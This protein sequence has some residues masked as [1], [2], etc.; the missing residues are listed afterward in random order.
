MKIVLDLSDL[1]ESGRVTSAEAER[2]R[3]LAAFTAQSLAVNLLVGFGLVA[4]VAGFAA[5]VP[6][7][8]TAVTL[9]AIALAGGLAIIFSRA[10]SWNLLGHICAVIGA[11][12]ICGGIS[13]LD[14]GSLRSVL[15]GVA[16]LAIV[17]VP[18]RSGLLVAIAVLA[19][20]VCLGSS[21]DYWHALYSLSI[22]QPTLTI[23]VFAIMALVTYLTSLRVSAAYERLAL[24]AARVAVLAVNFGFW[25]GSLQ[26]D[27]LDH[28]RPWFRRLP[29]SDGTDW[30]LT[31][32]PLAFS[33]A[34]AVAL[35]AVA[36]WALRVGRLWIVNTAAV[37]GA[38]HFYTQWFETLGA[39]PMTVL[40]AGVLVLVFAVGLWRINRVGMLAAPA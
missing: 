21:T 18:V 33:V 4:V 13:V 10:T 11:L 24:V 32:S 28:L 37:F 34:W 26:G 15:F 12:A 9:G 22:E 3:A 35:V 5:L 27:N 17:A 14:D 16:L 7:A 2:L 40:L 23:L 25:V 20:G 8:F 30:H 6:S 39:D 29:A 1:V 36:A 38:T 31:I 19:V